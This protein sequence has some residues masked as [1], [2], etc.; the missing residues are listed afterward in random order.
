MAEAEKEKRGG[1]VALSGQQRRF[2]EEVAGGRQPEQAYLAAFPNSRR[3][4]PETVELRAARLLAK[5]EVA[6]L[7]AALQ[8][9]PGGWFW[10]KAKSG[11]TLQWLIGQARRQAE[12]DGGLTG[13]VVTAVMSAVKELNQLHHVYAGSSEDGQLERLIAG[14]QGLDGADGPK[15]GQESGG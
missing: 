10:D 1:G 12:A 15:G 5:P 2:A 11:A 8:A 13:P 4:K 9:G 3:W 14:L 6:A 7:V